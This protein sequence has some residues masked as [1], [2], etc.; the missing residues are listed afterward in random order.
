MSDSAI[1][2]GAMPSLS[3][4]DPHARAAITTSYSM[5]VMPMVSSEAAIAWQYGRQVAATSTVADW[6]A[7]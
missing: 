3:W 7:S 4:S 5:P 6:Q 1:F 2:D